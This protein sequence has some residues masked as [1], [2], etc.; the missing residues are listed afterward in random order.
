M[1]LLRAGVWRVGAA[2][3][4]VNLKDYDANALN[5][6]T[7]AHAIETAKRPGYT[8]GSAD[9][10]RNFKA[11]ADRT[12]LTPGQVWA[13]Y[14]SKHFDAITSIMARPDLP[15]SEA[16]LGRFADAINYLKLGYA[17]FNERDDA[18]PDC[19]RDPGPDGL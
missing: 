14:A 13:V 5:L 11:V 6:L 1:D 15:V 12:G 2:E 10:L 3:V 18:T 7:E 16:P 9:V 4:V 8:V 19:D 17:L